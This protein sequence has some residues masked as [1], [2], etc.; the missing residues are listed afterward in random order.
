M[1]K[2][3]DDSSTAPSTKARGDAAEALA[4]RFL[5][6]QGLR[7]LDRQVRAA[8]VELDLVCEGREGDAP[9]IVFVEVRARSRGDLGHPLETIGAAKRGRLVKGATAWLVERGLWERVAV[10]FDVLTVSTNLERLAS[11]HDGDS[12]SG[13]EGVEW[14]AGAFESN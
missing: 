6:A 14:I 12:A 7:V 10:R 9:L 4:A 1:A 2:P 13:F 5:I 8:G 3:V 11:E